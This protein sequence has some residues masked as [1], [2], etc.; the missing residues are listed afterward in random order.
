MSGEARGASPLVLTGSAVS[1]LAV[2]RESKMLMPHTWKVVWRNEDPRHMAVIHVTEPK[3]L[4]AQH[5]FEPDYGPLCE[6]I[7]CRAILRT[8]VAEGWDASQVDDALGE[9][10]KGWSLNPQ[11]LMRGSGKS[12]LVV[13]YEAVR[14]HLVDGGRLR[15]CPM[16][17]VAVVAENF[18]LSQ[19]R[20]WLQAEVEQFGPFTG[21]WKELTEDCWKTHQGGDIKRVDESPHL[22]RKKEVK[23]G[24]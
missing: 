6:D 8:F 17:V 15:D 16:N 18:G 9:A 23:P 20:H 3:P 13:C 14:A 24:P 2:A 22:E 12:E 7:A 1:K 21:Q 5:E 19:W 10:V 4:W 11:R